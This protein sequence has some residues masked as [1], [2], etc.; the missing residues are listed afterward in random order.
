M[1][2]NTTMLWTRAT[3]DEPATLS[4]VMAT[5]QQDREG[6][7]RSRVAVGEGRARVA[8]EGQRDHRG[9]DPVR[10]VDEPGDDGGDVAFAEAAIDVLEQAT[11]GRE[12][13]A[14]LGERVALQ[15]GDR[16]GE[17]ERQP[18]GRTGDL[19][20]RAEQREDPGADHRGHADERGLERADACA[21]RA[22]TPP[23]SRPVRSGRE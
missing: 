15:R 23:S 18:D 21:R 8:P 5:Q 22:T 9:D 10:D 14:E 2:T 13:G 1:T 11:G 12:A 3:S 4:P 16:A 7:D 19:A 17:Q 20:G 6:L